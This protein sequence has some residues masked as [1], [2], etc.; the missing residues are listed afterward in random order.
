MVRWKKYL[1]FRN[2]LNAHPSA[3]NG[4]A[5]LKK[6]LVKSYDKDRK[7]YTKSKANF[8]KKIPMS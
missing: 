3:K 8:I 4:Y 2:Y 7:N 5:Q 6:S 1:G